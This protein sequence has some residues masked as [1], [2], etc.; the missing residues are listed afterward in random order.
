MAPERC[1]WWIHHVNHGADFAQQVF[2]QLRR[3]RVQKNL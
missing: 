2:V 3:A 1:D